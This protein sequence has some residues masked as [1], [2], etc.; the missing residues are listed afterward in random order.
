MCN[1]P[2]KEGVE[3]QIELPEDDANVFGRVLEY[4]YCD[5]FGGFNTPTQNI[6][7]AILADVYI[8]LEK[9]QL[10]RLK[11]LLIPTIFDDARD[12]ERIEYFFGAARKIYE[13]TPDSE[14][15]FP[16]YFKRTVTQTL[17]RRD[18]QSY[19][20]ANIKHCIFEGGKLAQDA[21][22]AYCIHVS[23]KH[24]ASKIFRKTQDM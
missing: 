1:G 23:T 12:A 13:N 14:A 16:D 8:M 9:Y 4:M 22:D 6:K 24:E 5:A 18:Q 15:L 3:Q 21:F 10:L 2:F 17:A 11:E 19:M 20:E 7:V